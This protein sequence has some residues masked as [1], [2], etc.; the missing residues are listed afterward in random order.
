[1][2]NALYDRAT[3]EWINGNVVISENIGALYAAPD[4]TIIMGGPGPRSAIM[5]GKYRE[6]AMHR[7]S[8]I[9]DSLTSQWLH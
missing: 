9:L 1:M 3:G 8:Q 2:N 5:R 7:E 6:T 4:G